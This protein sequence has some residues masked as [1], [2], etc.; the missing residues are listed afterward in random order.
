MDITFRSNPGRKFRNISLILSSHASF[1]VA[2]KDVNKSPGILKLL[3]EVLSFL[4]LNL[5]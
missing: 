2:E 3:L 1:K 4:S 5:T